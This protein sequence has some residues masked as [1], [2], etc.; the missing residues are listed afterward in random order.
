MENLILTYCFLILFL[1][2]SIMGL[3]LWEAKAKHRKRAT[4]KNQLTLCCISFISGLI[5][6][7]NY[8]MLPEAIAQKGALIA[9]TI[10]GVLTATFSLSIVF[11]FKSFFPSKTKS[12]DNVLVTSKSL[13][14]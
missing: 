1:V 13:Q 10:L 9:F 3:M 2:F 8:L 11:L 4:L 6:H 12:A 14:Y 5:L 7:L